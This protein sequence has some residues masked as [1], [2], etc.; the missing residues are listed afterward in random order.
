MAKEG[1]TLD[2]SDKAKEHKD[3]LEKDYEPLLKWLKD[4][5]LKDKIEKAV[6]SERLSTSPCALVASSYGWSGNMERIMRAQAYQK[7]QDPSQKW[8]HN[9]FSSARGCA[10]WIQ[11]FDTIIIKLYL[12]SAISSWWILCLDESFELSCEKTFLCDS[13]P[14][15]YINN[16]SLKKLFF[17]DCC[18]IGYCFKICIEF[19][20]TT[21]IKRRLWRLTPAIPSSRS[22]EIALIMITMTRPP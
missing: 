10:R 21:L 19:T 6:V 14:S 15:C 20:V 22:S 17:V 8:V 5:A 1:L 13:F 11:I 16:P 2:Q 3:Q 7:Q 9:Y 4:E 18:L 12:S